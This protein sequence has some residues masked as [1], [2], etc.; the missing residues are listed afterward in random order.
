MLLV[1]AVTNGPEKAAQ[2]LGA[3]VTATALEEALAYL[4]YANAAPNLVALVARMLFV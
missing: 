3:L 4:G 2:L 1:H